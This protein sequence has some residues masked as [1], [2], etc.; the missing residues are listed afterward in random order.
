M[1]ILVRPTHDTLVQGVH[2]VLSASS[3]KDSDLNIRKYYATFK[4]EAIV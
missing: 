2:G 4:I 3:G 1:N